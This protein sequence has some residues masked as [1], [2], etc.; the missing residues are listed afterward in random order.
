M[1]PDLAELQGPLPQIAE[2][3]APGEGVR[4]PGEDVNA[5]FVLCRAGERLLVNVLAGAARLRD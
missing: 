1:L 4:Q 5:G 3:I 2:F